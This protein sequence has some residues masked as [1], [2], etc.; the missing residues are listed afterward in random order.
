MAGG[1]LVKGVCTVEGVG[2]LRLRNPLYTP[3]NLITPACTN[4][5]FLLIL[6]ENGGVHM[7]TIYLLTGLL[8]MPG[9]VKEF[10]PYALLLEHVLLRIHSRNS[11]LLIVF[12]N[13]V[14]PPSNH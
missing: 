3:S 10:L 1:T 6:P 8:W 13:R 7:F 11:T 12:P 4:A 9:F 2:G 14:M 5:L